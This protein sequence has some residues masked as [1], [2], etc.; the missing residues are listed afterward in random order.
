MGPVHEAASR[1]QVRTRFRAGPNQ[2]RVARLVSRYD[3]YR[4]VKFLHVAVVVFG[5]GPTIALAV[6]G[7]RI[8]TA[9]IPARL[10]MTD[11]VVEIGRKL[12]RPLGI[13]ILLTGLLGTWIG[14]IEWEEPWIAI[15][16]V[17]WFVGFGIG[18]AVLQPAARRMKAI[19]EGLTGPPTEEQ[20]TEL[21]SLGRRQ[22][23]FGGVNHLVLTLLI[24]DM[25]WKPWA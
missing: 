22:A 18:E 2:I 19:Q 5:L 4:L 23:V 13:L 15:G 24:F 9:P 14:E 12:V 20:M 6:L 25:V 7:P 3:W 21:E 17:L 11:V 1:H 16:I 10:P 8:G